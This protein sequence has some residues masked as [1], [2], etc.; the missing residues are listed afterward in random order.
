MKPFIPQELLVELNRITNG[1]VEIDVDFSKISRWK[2]GGIAKCLVRPNS[3][4]EVSNLVKLLSSRS[5]PYLVIGATTNL[6]FNDQRV[7]AVIIQIGS[8]MSQMK[9]IDNTHI[10]AQAGVWV[11]RFARSVATSGYTGLEHICG[12]P[13]TLG[14]LVCMNGGSQRKN[15]GS[16]IKEVVAVS[17]NGE[18]TTFNNYECEFEYRTSVFQ[19]N[20]YIITEII[21][22]FDKCK[23]Y[24][25]IRDEML[26]ILKS[27]RLKFPQKYPNCGSTFMSNSDLYKK[28]GPPGKII[29][30][31]GLKGFRIGGAEISSVHANFINNIDNASS[32]D[33]ISII[34]HITNLVYEKTGTYLNTEIRYVNENGRIAQINHDL[35]LI[36]EQ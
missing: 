19:L 14:G 4:I 23:E 15:I 31:L 22:K 25:V 8:T 5:V 35:I 17:P 12:I 13:G 21:L 18:I 32:N 20:G 33:V 3:T 34:K 29:E 27:R 30:D 2:I 28:F 10:W 24:S 11:P 7:E 6:L 1:N 16:H 26:E 36:T 9:D